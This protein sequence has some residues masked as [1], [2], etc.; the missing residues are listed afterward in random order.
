MVNIWNLRLGDLFKIPGSD[1]IL[2]YVKI[3]G[4]YSQALTRD[5]QMT[6]IGL[7]KVELVQG[8]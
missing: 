5:G 3:D 1:I 2:E 7:C 6:L 4:M 8:R